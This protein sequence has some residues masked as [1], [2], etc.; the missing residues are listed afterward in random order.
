MELLLI[1]HG[2]PKR[3]VNVDTPADP[4]LDDRGW[5]QAELL[6]EYL[7]PEGID[8]VW[9]SPLNRARQTAEPLAKLLGKEI[10]I[11]QHLAEWD[12]ESTAYIPIEELK[13]TNHPMWQA[14]VTGEWTGSEDPETFQR[15]V[16]GAVERAI[17]QY[18]GKRV[19]LVCHGGVINAYISHLLGTANSVGFFHP[20]YTSIHRVMASSS[21]VRSLR[22]LNETAHLRGTGLLG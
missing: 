8:E 11:E 10:T 15:N 7:E 22:S 3:I 17:T 1:R 6:A 2:L 19:A 4:P 16:V 21:G 20:E 18:P 13:A 5:R 9:A 12:R 14:M